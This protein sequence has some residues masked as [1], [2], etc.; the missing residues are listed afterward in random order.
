MKFTKNNAQAASFWPIRLE[1]YKC[2]MSGSYKCLVES[3]LL[4]SKHKCNI[5]AVTLDEFV[6]KLV[7]SLGL[8]IPTEH[9]SFEVYDKE[10]EEFVG[11]S[12]VHVA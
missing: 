8:P 3:D 11:E 2:R 7:T 1:R 10:F 4:D 12:R 9:L 5:T 6:A